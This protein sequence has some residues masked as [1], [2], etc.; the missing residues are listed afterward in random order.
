MQRNM[1]IHHRNETYHGFS[2]AHL[3]AAHRFSDLLWEED[4]FVL[5]LGTS[6]P[7][8]K[9][10]ENPLELAREGRKHL[11]I[12]FGTGTFDPLLEFNYLVPLSESV[13]FSLFATGRFPLYENSKGYRGSIEAAAI[14][15][16]RWA[17]AEWITLHANYTFYYQ[18]TARW[19]GER[20][21]NSGLV[22]HMGLVGAT[23]QLSED[24][25]IGLD[26]RFPIAQRT[27]Q[28]GG[29]WEFGPM[30]LVSVSF[31]F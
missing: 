4:G 14:P 2:D 15:T 1:E 3:L 17:A 18:S 20:D 28:G 23:F 11:H 26:L 21:P 6:L 8:G 31:G 22:A 25:S 12:Q 13:S 9:T 27:L 10:E 24:T 29:V 30:V 19:D 7:I 5:S 16:L